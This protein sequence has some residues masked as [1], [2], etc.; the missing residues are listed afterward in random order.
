VNRLTIIAS[1][2]F[3]LSAIAGCIRERTITGEVF[4]VGGVGMS[5]KLALANVCAYDFAEAQE[6]LQRKH[7]EAED[8]LATLSAYEKQAKALSDDPPWSLTQEIEKAIAYYRSPQF[9]FEK[10]PKPIAATKTNSDGKFTLTVP[11][12]RRIAIGANTHFQKRGDSEKEDSE[13]VFYWLVDPDNRTEVN[14]TSDNV[15]G[16]RGRMSMLHTTDAPVISSVESDESIQRRLAAFRASLANNVQPPPNGGDTAAVPT[17]TPQ[18]IT[19]I[20]PTKIAVPYGEVTLARGMRLEVI[21]RSGQS[22]VIRY[23]GQNYSVPI[24]ATDVK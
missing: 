17:P 15:A 21:S 9:Y 24:N 7:I 6:Y 22:L 16:S 19:I 13:I 8:H 20:S 5:Y 12:N 23:M 4:L 11:T 10:L 1:I 18:L 3:V 14:L 2:A